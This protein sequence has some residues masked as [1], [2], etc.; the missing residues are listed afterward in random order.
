[1]PL[2]A[3]DVTAL[4]LDEEENLKL[5]QINATHVGILDQLGDPGNPLYTEPHS[6]AEH[7]DAMMIGTR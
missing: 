5:E 7:F 3:I 4:L 1:M 6:M 2:P